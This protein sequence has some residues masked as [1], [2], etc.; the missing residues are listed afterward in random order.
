MFSC[1]ERV[2]NLLLKTLKS[3]YLTTNKFIT[4]ATLFWGCFWFFWDLPRIKDEVSVEY[5]LSELVHSLYLGRVQLVLYTCCRKFSICC[6]CW[7]GS[8]AAVLH[9]G[10]GFF[11]LHYWKCQDWWCYGA[12]GE[13]LCWWPRSPALVC[14]CRKWVSF[15]MLSSSHGGVLRCRVKV[16][17]GFN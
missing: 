3:P 5:W 12:G 15:I 6:G 14:M 17:R 7:A 13:V 11:W 9:E 4:R 10:L 16:K 2:L 8:A 1:Q